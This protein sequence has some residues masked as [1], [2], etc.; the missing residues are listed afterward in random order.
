MRALLATDILRVWE[1]GERQAPL[2]RAL[3]LLAGGCTETKAGEL[4]NLNVRQRD[5][6]LLALRELTFGSKLEGVTECPKCQER[7]EFTQETICLRNTD[8]SAPRQE[9]YELIEE[10]LAIRF[11]LPNSDDIAVAVAC[12]DTDMGRRLL[13]ERCVL[14][15]SSNGAELPRC[16]LPAA[17]L[18][19]LANRMGECAGEADLLL[20]FACPACRHRWQAIFDVVAFFWT[21]IAAHAKRVLS[22]VHTLACAYGWR[23]ADILAMSAK[24]RQHYIALIG[25]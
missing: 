9:E 20:D 15:A 22:E 25:P 23:E 24:R 5:A 21:E 14:H 12:E 19:S 18:D 11:R 4:A 1:Q 7:L 10:N 8:P 3:T 16:D 6:Q 17:V 13:A 2:A